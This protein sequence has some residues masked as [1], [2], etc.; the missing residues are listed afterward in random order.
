MR[1]QFN[2]TFISHNR[3]SEDV[4]RLSRLRRTSTLSCSLQESFCVRGSPSPLHFISRFF[5]FTLYEVPEVLVLSA[6]HGYLSWFWSLTLLGRVSLHTVNKLN[7]LTY[8]WVRFIHHVQL[9]NTQNSAGSHRRALEHSPHFW[10]K[11]KRIMM[12]SSG[13]E[14]RQN[15]KTLDGCVQR[16]NQSWTFDI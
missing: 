9:T 7:L 13:S 4:Y 3:T 2:G 5:Q 15:R 6:G 16:E 11:E 14:N 1:S 8:E 12:G 10:R